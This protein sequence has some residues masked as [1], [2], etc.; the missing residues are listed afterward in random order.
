MTSP[1]PS[2]RISTLQ[3]QA[4][5]NARSAFLCLPKGDALFEK[6]IAQPDTL[7]EVIKMMSQN[8]RSF[9][10]RRT[11]RLLEQLQRNTLWLQ[12]FSGVVDVV[13][14][15][16]AGIGCPLWAPLKLVLLVC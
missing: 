9:K 8:Y 6:C 16:Q 1:G 15:T 4:V 12:N 10:N 13:V 2:Q 7:P 11:T 5:E 3:Q 14:Q